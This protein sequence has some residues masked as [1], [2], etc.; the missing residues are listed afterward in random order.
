MSSE[1]DRFSGGKGS[2]PPMDEGWWAAILKE[3]EGRDSPLR[4]RHAGTSVG[5]NTGPGTAEDW[6]WART[7]YD[8]D[9]T[10]NLKVIGYNRGGLL[11]EARGLRG[12]VPVSHLV[13]VQPSEAQDERSRQLA[14]FVGRDLCLKVIEYDPERGRLVFSERAALAGPGQREALLSCLEEGRTVRG[15]VTNLTSFGVFVDLG[16]VEGLIHVSELSWGRVRHPEDVLACGQ[17]VEALVLS[18]DREQCR[19]ALSLKGLQPDPWSSV[20]ERFEVGQLV[21]GVV[22][23]VV[24]FGAFVGIEDGLEGLIHISE[25]GDGDFVHPRDVLRE[26]EHVR[27]RVVHIDPAGRR[28]ALSLRQVSQSEQTSESS[29]SGQ[30]RAPISSF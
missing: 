19:V 8:A 30:E 27:A 13:K 10:L 18:V 25:L 26:G 24:K 28:L 5:R 14:E 20:A 16:G 4:H 6:S 29:E 3:D 22:T 9:D 15:V 21:E 1:A 11:V 23:N 12:F 17:E 7:L 2:P